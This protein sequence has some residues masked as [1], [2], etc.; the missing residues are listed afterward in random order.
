MGRI[1]NGTK[2]RKG[3][4]HGK[5]RTYIAFKNNFGREHY[6]SIINNFD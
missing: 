5:L 1:N 2:K 3:K 4:K 6:L